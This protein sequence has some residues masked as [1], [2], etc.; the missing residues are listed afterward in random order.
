MKLWHSISLSSY[1]VNS[2]FSL[3]ASLYLYG[4]YLYVS[5][6]QFIPLSKQCYGNWKNNCFSH[7]HGNYCLG[8]KFLQQ[9][10]PRLNPNYHWEKTVKQISTQRKLLQ[11][12]IL[13]SITKV[14]DASS[15][16]KKTSIFLHYIFA[17]CTHIT[18]G[19]LICC[20]TYFVFH[21]S[22]WYS[23]TFCAK[24]L[25]VFGRKL[26]KTEIRKT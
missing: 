4:L 19:Y 11:R 9:V 20:L 12:C 3:I 2:I 6:E 18:Q 5:D 25:L 26:R 21:K 23:L 16:F 15:R 22:S 17:I 1:P 8:D 7:F 24:P 10:M 14:N 13:H